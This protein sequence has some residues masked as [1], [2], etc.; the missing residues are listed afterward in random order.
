MKNST[1]GIYDKNLATDKL[2]NTDKQLKIVNT[3]CQ[4]WH[5]GLAPL[6]DRH[7]AKSGPNYA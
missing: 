3:H 5:P 7:H 2:R 6:N 1:S 4:L